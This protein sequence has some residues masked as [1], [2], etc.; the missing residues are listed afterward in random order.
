LTTYLRAQF[1]D[2]LNQFTLTSSYFNKKDIK[3]IRLKMTWI[4]YFFFFLVATW[5][6][7]T[8]ISYFVKAYILEYMEIKSIKPTIEDEISHQIPLKIASLSLRCGFRFSWV[9]YITCWIR[10]EYFVFC[11]FLTK[12][13]FVILRNHNLLT[14]NR[15]P[16]KKMHSYEKH[17]ARAKT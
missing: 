5:I 7:I 3:R 8:S 16:L 4:Y 10:T 2:Y 1:F 17:E 6:Y 13:S 15:T 12:I 11:F 14:P 9:L